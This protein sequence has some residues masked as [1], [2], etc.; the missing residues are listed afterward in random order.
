MPQLN[1]TVFSVAMQTRS[2]RERGFSLLEVLVALLVLSIGLLGIAGLQTFSL[3][4]N[5][6]SYERTQATVLI[7]EMYEKIIANPAAARNGLFNAVADASTSGSYA[8][9]G[10]P[11][12][13]TNSN[14]LATYDI[15]IWKSA[16]ETGSVLSQGQGSITRIQN[17]ADPNALVFDITVR[18]VENDLNMAM[19][20][21]ARTL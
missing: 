18:W 9:T 6:Q 21:R 17:P 7:S 20:M 2:G 15:F 19:S 13:C 3:K 10:C 16:L 5:H 8:G 12:A 14:E 11:T 4:F 1:T